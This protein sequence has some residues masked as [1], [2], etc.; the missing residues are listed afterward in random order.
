MGIPNLPTLLAIALNVAIF[1]AWCSRYYSR[2]DSPEA[3]PTVKYDI[4]WVGHL[5]PFLMRPITFLDRCRE[6]YG[7]VYKIVVGGQ[8]I[9]IISSPHSILSLQTKSTKE[10]GPIE[11]QKIASLAGLPKKRVPELFHTLHRRIYPI[12]TGSFTPRFVGVFTT[13]TVSNLCS[14]IAKFVPGDSKAFVSVNLHDFIAR[15]IHRASVSTIWGPHFPDTFDDFADLD[16]N[17]FTV[18]SSIPGFGRRGYAA[19][20][21]LA[22]KIRVFM[23]ERWKEGEEGVDGHLEGASEEMSAAIAEL[24]KH[25]VADEEVARCLVAI[26]WGAHGNMLS[27]ATWLM[28]YLTSNPYAFIRVRDAV[29]KAYPSTIPDPHALVDN[30][31][32]VPILDSAIKETM[33]LVLLPTSVREAL[34]DVTLADEGGRQYVVKKGEQIITDVRGMHLDPTYHGTDARAFKVDRFVGAEAKYGDYE[35]VKTLVPW[36]GGMFMCKGREYAQR[37]IKVFFIIFF[38]L[39]DV[40]LWGFPLPAFDE[41]S[42]SVLH[43]AESMP[44][45]KLRRRRDSDVPADDIK[46]MAA[47]AA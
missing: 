19:R 34:C 4:P 23:A 33:R 27:V 44:P 7:K 36:G 22:D 24:K 25:D 46:E 37:V 2:V 41:W 32:D 45:M 40:E 8:S 43:P 14:L 28:L 11:F 13:P 21:R 29:R 30:F 39:Y 26:M 47:M 20:E 12:A 38:Q 35:G 6:R 42:V 3:P 16:E 5:V 18:L 10:L 31:Q 17:M 9:V 1:I 15:T